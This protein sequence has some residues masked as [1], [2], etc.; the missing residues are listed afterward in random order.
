MTEG[1]G[2][3]KR[4]TMVG[5][6][7][8]RALTQGNIEIA[9]IAEELGRN[10]STIHKWLN[11]GQM[12]KDASLA[13]EAL[14]RRMGGERHQ[15]LLIRGNSNKMAELKPVLDAFGFEYKEMGGPF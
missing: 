11:D 10:T 1:N 12:P 4:F 8:L 2:K 6:E 15:F 9:Q 13:C 3:P 14:R 7:N 5:T